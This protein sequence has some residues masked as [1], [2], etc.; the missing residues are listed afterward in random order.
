[1]GG[2][3]VGLFYYGDAPFASGRPGE[4]KPV[5]RRWLSPRGWG[6]RL[7]DWGLRWPLWIGLGL[8]A[9]TGL[10]SHGSAFSLPWQPP[11]DGNSLFLSV[12]ASIAAV[13]IPVLLLVIERAGEYE[14]ILPISRAL[15]RRAFGMPLVFYTWIGL[16]AMLL[17]PSPA[18]GFWVVVLSI[19]GLTF[20]YGRLSILVR[21]RR[22]LEEEALDLLTRAMSWKDYGEVAQRMEQIARLGLRAA[23]REEWAWVERALQAWEVAARRFAAQMER[24]L[25]RQ[26]YAG[27]DFL[28]RMIQA[29]ERIARTMDPF[30]PA[31]P[32]LMES[33]AQDLRGQLV[34]LPASLMRGGPDRPQEGNLAWG[35][36]L[37]LMRRLFPSAPAE[38]ARLMAEEWA[39]DLAREE[40]TWFGRD[41]HRIALLAWAAAS[42]GA[43]AALRGDFRAAEQF[44]EVL[45]RGGPR[46]Q[47]RDADYGAAALHF[48]AMV[49]GFI[50]GYEGPDRAALWRLLALDGPL[51]RAIRRDPFPAIARRAVERQEWLVRWVPIGSW[52]GHRGTAEGLQMALAWGA[53]VRC[54][55]G[56]GLGALDPELVRNWL[57]PGIKAW[58][59]MREPLGSLREAPT[60]RSSGTIGPFLQ[61]KHLVHQLWEQ[62]QCHEAT[63]DSPGGER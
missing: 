48:A 34:E 16:L 41:P 58:M 8:L 53:A 12:Q 27:E 21:D 22:A 4:G 14:E 50:R 38:L 45:A 33:P 9:L 57:C 26:P 63:Q 6:A 10:A 11:G 3:L 39:S 43:T 19:L 42:L 15:L 35:A 56:Q 62:L 17:W 13:A 7:L 29:G 32:L 59:E 44:A 2:L 24:D 55:G 51:D 31:L 28:Y 47:E 23:E 49:V 30:H 36:G 25:R 61:I 40:D 37:R 1:M 18:F 20:A 54:E 5:I 52:P 60:T 46:D